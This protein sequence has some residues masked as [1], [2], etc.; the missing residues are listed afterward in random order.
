M[1]DTFEDG[2]NA[3]R[4]GLSPLDNP[5]FADRKKVKL[6]NGWS[7][8]WMHEHNVDLVRNGKKPIWKPFRWKGS[9]NRYSDPYDFP[10]TVG[11]TKSFGTQTTP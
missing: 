9:I 1:S 4:S 3:Y 6:F 5:Y 10:N 7:D 2:R 11:L 8:G